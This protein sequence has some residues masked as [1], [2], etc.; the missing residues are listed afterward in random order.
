MAKKLTAKEKLI[1]AEEAYLKAYG[2][3]RIANPFNPKAFHWTPKAQCASVYPG[4]RV[5][6]ESALEAQKAAVNFPQY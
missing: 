4:D 6:R 5:F 1:K 2:W 3:Q